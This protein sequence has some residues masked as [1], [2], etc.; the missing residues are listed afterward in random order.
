VKISYRTVKRFPVA[1][2]LL[3]LCSIAS[4]NLSGFVALSAMGG[5]LLIGIINPAAGLAAGVCLDAF[6]DH[7]INY[8][9]A[10]IG[11]FS[12]LLIVC[13]LIGFFFRRGIR[14]NKVRLKQLSL[15]L[16]FFVL[17]IIS[18]TYAPNFLATV[19][20]LLMMGLNLLLFFMVINLN[21]AG[22]EECFRHWLSFCLVVT[23]YVCFRTFF[24]GVPFKDTVMLFGPTRLSL[25]I[26]TNPNQL[27]IGLG[28]LFPFLLYLVLKKKEPLLMKAASFVTIFFIIAVLFIIQSRNSII[29]CSLTAGFGSLLFLKM[30]GRLISGKTIVYLT[31]ITAISAAIVAT[32][33]AKLFNLQWMD[34][35]Q[36][37][38]FQTRISILK[39]SWSNIVM[40]NLIFGVGL[41]GHNEMAAMDDNAINSQPGAI[42]KPS[43]NL[44]LSLWA[45]LGL[46][47]LFTFVS[48][49]VQSLLAGMLS[50]RY[51]SNAYPF[52]MGLIAS[53]LLGIGETLFF[54]KIFWF[55]MAFCLSI[56]QDVKWISQTFQ[57][58]LSTMRSVTN[59]LGDV[60]E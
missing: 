42:V 21:Q 32:A 18:V 33:G 52:V 17:C 1:S 43:H 28:Q 26:H 48:L 35:F 53:V 3:A 30:N 13:T 58:R 34:R 8:S 31:F 47:G 55:C 51:A 54:T 22:K 10:F 25:D 46:L 6:P 19:I 11:S 36:T 50:F 29:C 49:I 23:F 20:S 7:F 4:A 38:E 37:A 45:Q 59:P 12:R 56:R 40:E 15:P 27:G 57:T 14:Y 16:F 2:L 39:N 24:F 5:M 60:R 41:G 44:I 9:F